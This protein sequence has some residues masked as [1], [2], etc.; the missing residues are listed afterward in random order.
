MMDFNITSHPIP[1]RPTVFVM[2]VDRHISAETADYLRS[3]WN[4]KWI[5]AGAE[6]IPPV[7]ILTKGIIIHPLVTP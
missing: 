7:M 4:Q 3:E 1:D 5:E 2:S 6:N